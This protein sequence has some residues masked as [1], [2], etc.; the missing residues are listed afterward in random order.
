[1]RYT[2]KIFL[3]IFSF[4]SLK[5]LVFAQ[6]ARTDIVVVGGS[7]SGT[8]AALQAAR[9]GATVTL[10]EPT[11]W[12]GG[13]LTAA[14]VSATDGNH[15]MPAGL[16]GEFRDSLRKRYG[17]AAALET[18]WV[19]NTHFEPHVGAQILKNMLAREKN[20]RIYF[21]TNAVS[22]KK[23]TK[24]WKVDCIQVGAKK[25]F[26]IKTKI[27]IDATELGDVAKAV[28]AVYNIGTDDP[29]V[30]QEQGYAQAK[31]D[32]IQDFTFTAVLQNYG[33]GADKTIEKPLNFNAQEFACCCKTPLC[34]PLKKNV[35]D[36]DKMLS[37]AQL[38]N[39]KVLLNWPGVSGND[40]Y[41][42][43]LEMSPSER[44]VVFEA[45]K[46]RTWRYIYFI[47]TV[48]GFKHLGLPEN[49][50]PTADKLPLIPYFRESRRIEGQQLMNI[51]HILTPFKTS[52]YRTGVAVGDYPIDHHH[53][54]K[55]SVPNLVFPKVPSFNIPLGSLIPIKIDHFIVAEKSIAVTNIVN[56]SS[57]LQPCVMLIG[58]AAGALAAIC[59][60][61]KTSPKVAS[62]RQVQSALLAS[63]AYLMPYFDVKPEN[64]HFSSI[65]K[66]GATG[67]L[68]G[69]G[70][71]YLWA[72]RTWFYPDS[73]VKVAALLANIQDFESLKTSL[74][75]LNLSPEKTLNL[76]DLIAW[77]GA[78]TAINADDWQKLGL[79]NFD[80]Q[81]SATRLEV[82]VWLDKSCQ[83]F[84]NFDLDFQ[85][86]I[87]SK[88]KK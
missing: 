29:L 12:L 59:V 57:R 51:H 20:I 46:Q 8:T 69:V 79:E 47:Q 38:P 68:R 80:L 45:A 16:W 21:S 35:H 81:R 1:M 34:D 85:G 22:F 37:Y 52:A 25:G 63:K 73:T 84:Q 6:D 32:Y 43:M 87:L 17:S 88:K 58:Q 50:F 49:E 19:S 70:E 36:C 31:T 18:G 7:A 2:F 67:I 24:G 78:A 86:N 33:S 10:I 42:N 74:L 56:G 71:A 9:Q 77:G 75:A 76:S 65:Q 4:L 61:N 60:Q 66:I 28:G 30:T 55:T 15:N 23:T 40:Y 11:T 64:R 53:A 48:L 13:M 27:L 26:Q 5:P 3:F 14:G 44:Q 82:A 41:A 62:V 83:P 72:N 54:K 39:S